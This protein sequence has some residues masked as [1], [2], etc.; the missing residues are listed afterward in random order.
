MFYN[1][2]GYVLEPYSKAPLE[3]LHNDRVTDFSKLLY[4]ELFSIY[5]QNK[6]KNDY[7]FIKDETLAEKLN[8]SIRYIKKSMKD[9]EDNQLIK[10]KTSSYDKKKN[11]KNRKIFLTKLKRNK[12]NN[13]SYAM[14]PKAI[15]KKKDINNLS[16]IILI[17]LMSLLRVI[18]YEDASYGVIDITRLATNVG[19]HR[20]T[21]TNNLSGLSDKGYILISG[22]GSER[23]IHLEKEMIFNSGLYF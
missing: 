7:L 4:F 8:V 19:K 22:N 12:K 3:V 6:K 15:Y 11:A 17:E 1:F 10:R 9:L 14:F 18:D 13:I 5:D 2:E 16:K 21:I 20:R 23:T